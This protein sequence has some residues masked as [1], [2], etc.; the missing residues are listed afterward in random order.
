MKQR[1]ISEELRILRAL[2]N[3]M[4]FSEEEERLYANLEKGYQGE[5]AFDR[6]AEKLKADMIVLNDICLEFN[7]AVFQIDTLIISQKEVFLLEIKNYTG[8]YLYEAGDIRAV[9]SQFDLTNPL[10]QLN[11][12]QTLPP[13]CC[14][15][16]DTTMQ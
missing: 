11:R 14:S 16:Q 10:H 15:N 4:D 2:N 7:H 13:L 8:D 1:L 12:I 5:V 3:R 9:S 6:L